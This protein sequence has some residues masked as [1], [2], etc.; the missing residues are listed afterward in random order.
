MK[1]LAVMN[2]IP[3]IDIML[4]LLAIVLTTS[5][6]LAQGKIPLRLPDANKAVSIPHDKMLEI[7]ID[8]AG[9]IYLDEQAIKADMLANRLDDTT[10]N[11]PIMLRVDKRAD[12]LHFV[13]VIDQLKAK[14]LGNLSIVTN[15]AGS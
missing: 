8:E 5:T 14:G 15:R 11:T 13:V 4:V 2:V 12:F 10:T 6:F 1:P 3:F 9:N 7:S